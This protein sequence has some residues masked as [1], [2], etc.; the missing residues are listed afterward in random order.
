MISICLH[1]LPQWPQ[2][3]I[4]TLATVLGMV[5]VTVVSINKLLVIIVAAAIVV[6]AAV[7]DL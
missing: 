6:V 1:K 5:A 3:Y 2:F 4:A 7:V